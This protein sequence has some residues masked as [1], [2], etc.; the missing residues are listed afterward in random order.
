MVLKIN[1][2]K[3]KLRFFGRY[4]IHDEKVILD[5]VGSGFELK[6][7]GDSIRVFV[8]T[9]A[10]D[11]PV[12]V[13]MEIDGKGQKTA[14][15]NSNEVLM[16][17]GLERGEHSFKL[18]R[19]TEIYSPIDNVN[20]YLYITGIELGR[21]DNFELLDFP[22]MKKTVIDFYGD[23]IT[24]A[25]ASLAEPDSEERRIC[26]NDYTVSYAYLVSE[27]LNA[28]ARVCAVSGHG[29]VASCD[30]VRDEPM[31][32]FYK[33]KCRSLPVEMD[34]EPKPDIV[35]IALGTNDQGGGISDCEFAKAAKDFVAMVRNDAP[36]AEIIWMYGMM[37][38][39]YKP[40]LRE[41]FDELKQTDKHV[42]YLPIENVKREN[43]ETGAF[44]HPNKK[45]ERRIADELLKHI[46]NIMRY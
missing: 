23:S 24:N 3:D 2:V 4:A 25:W 6:F 37:N 36:N 21:E 31:K 22:K 11:T 29:I 28:D 5:W 30:G 38:V 44:G 13:Y 10:C 1:K 14:V 46:K 7:K 16:V 9:N 15:S 32:R 18:L 41:L 39:K 26:D 17:D 12:Y 34:F 19:I 42:S 27:K 43:K 20:D 45:G 8:Q 35:V 40:V 33:M